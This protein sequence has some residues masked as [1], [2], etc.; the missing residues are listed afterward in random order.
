MSDR[1]SVLVSGNVP[2]HLMTF[3]GLL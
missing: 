1:E 2:M 3:V